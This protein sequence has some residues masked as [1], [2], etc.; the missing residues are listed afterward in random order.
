MFTVRGSQ[1]PFHHFSLQ[2]YCFFLTYANKSAEIRKLLD[3][4]WTIIGLLLY[5]Y[6]TIKLRPSGLNPA[7]N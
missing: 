1:M 5:Y 6:C 2:K 4:Y 3:Y 7:F